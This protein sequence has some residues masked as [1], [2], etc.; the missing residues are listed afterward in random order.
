MLF[1]LSTVL[2]TVSLLGPASSERFVSWRGR[3]VAGGAGWTQVFQFTQLV[4]MKRL[5][6]CRESG[7]EILVHLLIE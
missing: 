6:R 4:L 2:S 7:L 5:Q 3:S 1:I